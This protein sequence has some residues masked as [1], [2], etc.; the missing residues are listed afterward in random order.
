M[1][2]GS[3]RLRGLR[4]YGGARRASVAL[5]TF[6]LAFMLIAPTALA[7]H[8]EG[9]F[10][11][12]GNAESS[13]AD[14]DDW[15]AIE[16][17]GGNAIATSFI[18]DGADP[19]DTTYLHQGG[20][21]DIEDFSEWVRT[22]TDEA[23]DKDEIMHAFAAAYEASDGDFIVY[24]GLDRFDASGDAQV[25][26]WFTQDSISIDGANV[27]GS[28]Q[29]GD[30]LVLSD[31][32]NGGSVPEIRVF[33]WVGSGGSDGSIDEVT[34]SGD[35]D[36]AAAGAGDER[37]AIVN[38]DTENAPWSFTNKSGGHDFLA[39]ELY[40][41]GINLTELGIDV[42]CI[43]TFIAESRTS[44]STDARLKDV[45]MGEFPV[46]GIEVEKDGDSI[47]KVGDQAHY[48]ITVTNTGVVKLYKESIV[49]DILG[50]LT[51]GTD[52]NITSTTCG[53]S[54]NAGDDCTIELSYTVQEGDDD[55]L[56]NTVDVVYDSK[57]NLTGSE[58]SSSDSHSLNL[59]QPSVVVE[60]T[61][62]TEA[63]VGQ[64]V[65]YNF[66]ITNTSSDDAPDLVMDSISDSVLGDLADDAPA[67]CDTLASGESCSFTVDRE[68]QADDPDPLPN[69]V[70][71]HYHP[72]GFPNDISD[73]DDH[74]VGLFAPSV[75]IS[76][77]GDTIGKV[78]DPV[79]YHFEI[80]NTS[81]EDSPDLILDSISD[82][83]LG[84]LEDA[85]KDAGC[86][87]L[88]PGE[89]CSFDAQRVVQE[90]DPDPLP[91]TVTV[92]YHPE[93]FATDVSDTDDHS[94]NLFQPGVVI[95]KGGDG[96]SIVGDNVHYTFEITNTS[97]DDAP[98]LLLESIT[99]T[100]LGDLS[101][102]APAACD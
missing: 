72:E 63:E 8:D 35:P 102:E 12:D 26:F 25:G 66:E 61:G 101:D 32:V 90:G 86:D 97:S 21:K 40:E 64:T 73:T 82:T 96:T 44:Q 4:L 33:T 31:F 87:V 28:H 92:H 55:P 47:S 42:G 75:T 9:L 3:E 49:D 24:F 14:G 27:V 83:L 68:V 100:L 50:D 45:A 58:L 76:K 54:L 38:A 2:M 71:V 85:A 93:G 98:D 5:L 65:T 6:L 10:E 16:A 77:T 70:T 19:Q 84:D 59:F 23:P 79:D 11:L 74:S 91:N 52:A 67:A 17:G 36:C 43:T 37:C 48:E 62:D 30:I 7:V 56:V 78:T 51:D 39:G 41:G 46:C 88:S 22:T 80:E 18:N 60:K 69:T 13:A 57:S 94:V 20:S 15:E 81:S 34:S 89:S 95:E 99:D 1:Q 29:V 53:A